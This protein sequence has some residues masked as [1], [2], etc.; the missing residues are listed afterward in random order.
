MQATLGSAVLCSDTTLRLETDADSGLA[1]WTP[2]G[3]SSEAPLI[4]AGHKIGIKL[5][6]GAYTRPLFSP[7]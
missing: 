3:N 4:V 7:A 5:E 1:K 2:R 6:A